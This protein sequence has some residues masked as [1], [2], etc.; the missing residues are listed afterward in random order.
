MIHVET[1]VDFPEILLL[2]HSTSI[3]EQLEA[4]TGSLDEYTHTQPTGSRYDYF[5]SG[6][7]RISVVVEI[8]RDRVRR[9]HQ[10]LGIEAEGTVNSLVSKENRQFYE[11]RGYKDRP[12]RRFHL[13]QIASASE[14]KVIIGWEHSPRSPTARSN[15]KTF[16]E[17]EIDVP[18][19]FPLTEEVAEPQVLYEGAVC[20]VTVNAYERNAKA[21]KECIKHYGANCVICGCSLDAL[22][23]PLAEGFI[24]VH[25]VKP[26]SEIGKEYQ[27]H[28]INDLRPVCPNC[29]AVI[30]LGSGS[31]SI[32]EVKQL[33]EQAKA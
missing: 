12:A 18:A 25:H 31:R 22:Y 6:R 16:W 19:A 33:I 15:G 26:I 13:Q 32:E 21:R 1:G 29:H 27:I 4:A 20:R 11:A 8:V 5:A 23:G 9:V 24:H 30:H 2:R 3:V 17:I 7:P 14:D 10:V 28:P